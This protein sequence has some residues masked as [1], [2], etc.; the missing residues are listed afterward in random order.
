MRSLSVDSKRGRQ[1][2]LGK[3][4]VRILQCVPVEQ[5][6]LVD[7]VKGNCSI[8][9]VAAVDFSSSN[10]DGED[11]DFPRFNAESEEQ[12]QNFKEEKVSLK[13]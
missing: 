3:A 1:D 4:V 6:S 10:V 7:Y 11:E 9:F 2:S 5:F 8:N 12:F 13:T